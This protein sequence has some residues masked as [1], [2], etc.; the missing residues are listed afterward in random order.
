VPD[1]EHAAWCVA[2]FTRD[3][4]GRTIRIDWCVMKRRVRG[5]EPKYRDSEV[6]LCGYFVV[7]PCGYERRAPTCADCV[8][9]RG[10]GVRPRAVV[11]QVECAA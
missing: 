9:K 11:D 7:L 8:E 2:W 1:L 5:V 3:T 4:A 10:R 6:T